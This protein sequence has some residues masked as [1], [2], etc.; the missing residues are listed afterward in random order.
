MKKLLPLV[1]LIIILSGTACEEEVEP[2]PPPAP[3]NTPAEV[4]KSV[5]ISF[6]QRDIEILKNSLSPDFVFYFDPDDVGQN[7]PGSQYRIPES[8][9]YTE[10]WQA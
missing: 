6:N 5:E 1:A 4:L 3:L 7:P 2:P 8:W 10:F 9:S